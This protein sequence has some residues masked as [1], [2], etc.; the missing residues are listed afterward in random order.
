MTSRPDFDAHLRAAER[1]AAVLPPVV[2]ALAAHLSACL[3]R[4]AR[5]LVCGNGGSAADAQHFAAECVWRLRADR[6]PIPVLALTTDTSLLTAMV[7]DGGA[8]HVFARQV[9]AFGK[10]GDVLLAV[11]TSGRSRNVRIAADTARAAGLEVIALT[12][13]DGGELA[14]DAT[15]AIRVPAADVPRIQELHGL[16][17]HALAAELERLRH[18]TETAP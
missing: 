10:P 14:A 16:V 4:G 5:V 3:D 2:D 8:D 11:S 13:E 15:R 7:N 9:R 12:G 6:A 17:L 1:A 18:G